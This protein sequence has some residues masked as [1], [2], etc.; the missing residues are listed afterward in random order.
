LKL[1]EMRRI[2]LVLAIYMCVPATTASDRTDERVFREWQKVFGKAEEYAKLNSSEIEQRFQTFMSN[3][4][5]IDQHNALNTSYTL[6]LNAF[7]DMTKAQYRALHPKR[8]HRRSATATAPFPN[9]FL[10]EVPSSWDWC[11]KGAVSPVKNQFEPHSCG[12]CWAFSAVA[13]IESRYAMDGNKVQSFSAQNVVD[14]TL[15]GTD[16]CSEGGEMHDGVM[17]VAVDQKGAINTEKQYPYNGY[18]KGVCHFNQGTAVETNVTGYSNVTVGDETALAQA[19]YNGGVV[20]AGIN[21]DADAFMFY[22]G[23]I[24]D[25]PKGK[26]SAKPQDLDHGVAIVGWG[27]DGSKEYWLVKNSYGPYWGEKGYFRIVRG[28]NS[29]GIATDCIVVLS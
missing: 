18:S 5:A 4:Q 22:S 2:A 19:V 1:Q 8:S 12:A 14:C 24:L 3:R 17:Q 15:N 29:C 23:G 25:I 20:P 10:T 16:T 28:R 27:M 9:A 11:K 7:A 6:G 26:C 21:S 13:G